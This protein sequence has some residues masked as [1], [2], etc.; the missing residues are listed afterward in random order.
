[1]MHSSYINN[2]QVSFCEFVSKYYLFA[3]SDRIYI[4]DRLFSLN[5]VC[6]LGVLSNLRI[7]DV[8]R[9]QG[10]QVYGKVRTRQTVSL[11]ALQ[12]Q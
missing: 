10:I 7:R 6:F 2:L 11:Q 9:L 1:M 3:I 8:V 12:D 5:R 4:T